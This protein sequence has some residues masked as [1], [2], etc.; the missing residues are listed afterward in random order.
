MPLTEDIAKAYLSY[1]TH[2][3]SDPAE[4]PTPSRTHNWTAAGYLAHRYGYPAGIRS[5][6]F[7]PLAWLRPDLKAN[8]DFATL[9]LDH[10]PGGRLLE[11]GCGSGAALKEMEARGWSVEGVDFDPQAVKAA[12]A[13][14]LS[15]R[16]GTLEQQAYPD[17]SFDAIAMV[18]V[19]EHVP[20]PRGLL[21]ECRRILRP[22]GDLVAITPNAGSLGHRLFGPDWRGLE[23]PRHLHI[24]TRRSLEHIAKDAGFIDA[25]AAT[26]VRDADNLLVACRA[27]RRARQTGGEYKRRE[28]DRKWAETLQ[29]VEAM[30]MVIGFG[31]GEELLLRVGKN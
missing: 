19:I 24:F 31:F 2:D 16:L 4:G 21:R 8:L 20:D 9:Y 14:N 1:Y 28:S 7:G 18:H 10:H 12:R 25:R 23:P 29:F 11:V 15:V 22:G 27:L 26:T 3:G 13:R 6:L 5:R 30:L 17:D